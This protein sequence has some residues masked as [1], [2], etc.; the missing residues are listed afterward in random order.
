MRL[1]SF[2]YEGVIE[3]GLVTGDSIVGL[4]AAGFVDMVSVIRGGPEARDAI[5]RWTYSAPGGRVHP[6]EAVR[7]LAPVPRP[8]KLISVGV[9][10]PDA[11]L[12]SAKFSTAV[13]GPGAAILLPKVSR[14]T[15]FEPALAV[16]IGLRGR[17]IP[18]ARWR[19][20][21]FG[22]M[23]ANDVSARD[24]ESVASLSMLA[25]TFDTFAPLGPWLVTADEAGNP[26]DLTVRASL[27]GSVWRQSST[28]RLV[29]ELPDLISNVSAVCTL[30]P[31][32]VIAA[33]TVGEQTHTPP[34]WL[35]PGDE[36]TVE[37]ERLGVLRN[38]ALAE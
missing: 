23:A 27:N 35:Q 38:R 7:L 32:D 9:N 13:I 37:I 5:E 8:G 2:E 17:H 26:S 10:P 11:P 33:V 4:R 28:R 25:G 16:V 21:V 14:K 3:P 22:F 31:G 19:E 30:E 18:A 1:A 20:H 24:L 29:L 12:I 6:L 34:R 36:V 15:G